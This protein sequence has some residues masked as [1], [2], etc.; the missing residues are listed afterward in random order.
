MAA[1]LLFVFAWLG[2]DWATRFQYVVM[3]VLVAALASFFA[4]GLLRWDSTLLVQTVW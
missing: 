2:A 4:G 1:G 3:T